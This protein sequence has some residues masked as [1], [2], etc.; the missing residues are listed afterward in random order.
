MQKKIIMVATTIHLFMALALF[1]IQNWIGSKSYSRG[2]I[3]FSLL[4][5]KDEALSFNFVIKVFG[6][7]VYLII[8]VAILQY[9]HCNQFLFNIINVVYYYILIRIITIF[10][11]ERSSIVNW[12]RI[13]FYYSSILIISSI[14]CSKFINSVDNLLPD[15]SEIKNEIWLLIIIFLYQVGNRTEEILPKEPYETSR[16]YLPELKQRKKRYILKKYSHYK[17]EYWN[18]IDKISNQN[19]QINTTIIAILIF[20]NFNRPP[21]IRFVERCLIKITKKEMTLGIMQVSSNRAISDT[22]S[23]VIGTENLCSKFRKNQ[24]ESETARFRLMIKHHCPD[25]K[26]IRQVLFITKCI[27]DN[28]DNRYDYSHLYSEIEHEFEL[29]ETI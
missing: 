17:K 9:F 16:A 18:I 6:P 10:L 7:I 11:Y 13:I 26:Y 12:W 27:I 24:K 20:E 23:V 19:R 8:M 28:L 25:R 15:F 3:K 22:Q 4:D 5:D 21:I 29:Y 14:I 1:L 2:Y